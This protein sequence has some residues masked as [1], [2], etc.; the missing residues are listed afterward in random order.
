MSSFDDD[1]EFSSWN[2]Q[3][4]LAQQRRNVLALEDIQSGRIRP[5]DWTVRS[6]VKV[7]RIPTQLES[8]IDKLKVPRLIQ[9]RSDV[10]KVIAGPWLSKFGK[11]LGQLDT[12]TVTYGGGLTIAGLGRWATEAELDSL[13]P[14]AFDGKRWDSCMG[15]GQLAFLRKVY[16]RAGCPD[17]VM[18]FLNARCQEIVGATS[19]GIKY[20]RLAQVSS[21]DPDTSCGNSLIN[22]VGWRFVLAQIL[23]KETLGSCRVLV[24]GD[25]SVVAVPNFV[26]AKVRARAPELWYELGVIM[27]ESLF[28]GDWDIVEF[29]SGHFWQHDRSRIFGPKPG[30]VIGKTFWCLHNYNK[31]KQKKWLRGLCLGL[32]LISG[33]VPILGGLVRRLLRLLG[34]GGALRRREELPWFN[35]DKIYTLSP[36]AVQQ[37]SIISGLSPPKIMS[38]ELEASGIASINKHFK[39]EHWS[40]LFQSSEEP[41]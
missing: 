40:Q 25:D 7:E 39:G 29:C 15:P 4:P 26:V 18:T 17:E 27:E 36:S 22:M 6:F 13:V 16:K 12:T 23:T 28:S 19:K 33:H 5:N 1:A 31:N 32:Q 8:L 2:S 38:M 41:F 20:G 35:S 10:A 11:A 34:P 3:Y 9:G 14:L 30:R 37:L 24:M 21:G